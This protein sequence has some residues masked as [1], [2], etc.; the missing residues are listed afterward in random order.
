MN[1]RHNVE[2]QSPG[3]R[4]MISHELRHYPHIADAEFNAQTYQFTE[5]PTVTVHMPLETW[6]MIVTTMDERTKHHEHPTVREAYSQYRM[7]KLLVERHR[8]E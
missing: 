2:V 7:L 5:A 1:W 4:R 6:E 8:E 3:Q